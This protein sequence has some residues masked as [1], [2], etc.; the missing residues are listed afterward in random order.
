MAMRD[1]IQE[2]KGFALQELEDKFLNDEQELQK[3]VINKRYLEDKAA[4]YAREKRQNSRLIKIFTSVG[5]LASLALIPLTSSAFLLTKGIMTAIPLLFAGIA[6]VAL[7]NR[8]K[9]LSKNM[10]IIHLLLKI[11]DDYQKKL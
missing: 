8:N 7:N 9:S 10:F 2:I 6:H 3:R 1:P 4:Q 11:Q 5:V